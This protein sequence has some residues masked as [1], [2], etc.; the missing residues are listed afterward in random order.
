MKKALNSLAKELF[1]K[2]SGIEAGNEKKTE[3]KHRKKEGEQESRKPELNM[4]ARRRW[5]L[6]RNT[7]FAFKVDKE[8]EEVRKR[9]KTS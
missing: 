9:V 2:T 6:V 7:C 1:T 8:I 3:P 5:K 4:D